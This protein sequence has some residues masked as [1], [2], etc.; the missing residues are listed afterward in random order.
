M[1][2]ARKKYKNRINFKV[3]QTWLKGKAKIYKI[4]VPELKA[5]GGRSSSETLWE[6]S[7]TDRVSFFSSVSILDAY[8]L[9]KAPPEYPK[10]PLDEARD[11][12]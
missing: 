6:S 5:D 11:F 10:Y 2:D 1:E 4:E 7:P 8:L 3:Q 9:N 12:S